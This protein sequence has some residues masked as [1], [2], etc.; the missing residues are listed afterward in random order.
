MATLF[1]WMYWAEVAAKGLACFSVSLVCSTSLFAILS[2]FVFL[3]LL[4]GPPKSATASPP[5]FLALIKIQPCYLSLRDIL[6]CQIF[7][8]S[9]CVR[10]PLDKTCDR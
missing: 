2:Y 6:Q 7:G 8:E 10:E 3:L 4:K 1:T 5:V 9:A